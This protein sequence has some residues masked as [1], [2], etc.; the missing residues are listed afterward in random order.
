MKVKVI[1]NHLG[2]GVFP[3][4]EKGTE[5]TVKETCTHFLHW[6]ACEIAGYQTYIP[7]IFVSEGKLTRN[8]NPTELIQNEGDIVEVQEIIYAWLIATNEK[9]VTGWLPAEIVVSVNEGK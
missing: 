5:V 6:Y 2:E 4:F 8:Y 7:S 3:T 9:G 1:K